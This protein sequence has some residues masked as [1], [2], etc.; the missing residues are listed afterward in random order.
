MANLRLLPV[1]LLLSAVFSTCKLD[2]L[3]DPIIIPVL[4]EEF[5]LN[6]W[7]NLGQGAN[8][9]LAIDIQSTTE[10]PCLNTGISSRY[11]R[12]GSAISLTLFDIVPPEVCDPGI[13]PAI[14]VESLGNVED[15]VFTLEIAIKDIVTNTGK[16]VV[17]PDYY[18]VQ[19][20]QEV[21]IKWTNYELR[22]I[23]ANTLWGYLTY[24]TSAQRDYAAVWLSSTLVANSQPANLTDGYYGYFNVSNGGTTLRIQ[25]MPTSGVIPFALRFTGNPADIDAWVAAFRAGA[26]VNQSV[27]IWDAAGRVW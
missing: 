6:L 11:E 10:Q 27:S 23:P 25:A 9:G 14:G 19:M 20:D 12:T 16:L 8:A 24:T 5:T 1:F 22:R 15:G 3:D 4:D 2:D 18:Q 7:E 21:G 13:A 17:T 26:A